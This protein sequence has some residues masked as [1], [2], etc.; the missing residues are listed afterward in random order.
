MH[1]TAYWFFRNRTLNAR[2][3]YATFNPPELRHQTGASLGGPII[4]DKLF[5]F[6]EYG[7]HAPQFPDLAA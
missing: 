1:G 4:K 5:Y 3:R 2:D 6:L 7:F